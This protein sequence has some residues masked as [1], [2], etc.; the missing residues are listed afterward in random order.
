MP[1]QSAKNEKKKTDTGLT[2]KSKESLEGEKRLREI[3]QEINQR[4]SEL[5]EERSQRQCYPLLMFTTKIGDRLVEDVFDDLRKEYSNCD[6]Q[7][8]IL[9]FSSGG[10]IDAAYN[11]ALLLRKFATKDLV[12]IIPRWAKSAAT[13]LACSGNRILMSPIAEL[14]PLDPQITEV[15]PLQRRM[16]Q[17]SPLHIEATLSLIREEFD[18][19]HEKLAKGLLER[20]QFPLTLGSFKKS[21]DIAKEYLEML[22][23]TRMLS[24]NNKQDNAKRMAEKLTQGYPDHSYCIDANEA[25]AIGLIVDDLEG[26]LLDIC[27]D[28]HKLGREKDNIKK[29][30]K[31]QQME[32]LLKELPP[33]LRDML[34]DFLK[35]SPAAKP[36]LP[37]EESSL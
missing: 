22:L 13:L 15:N 3:D 19:G 2:P 4:L 16:E 20:L 11:L 25:R 31:R 29:T 12:F 14:G 37:P 6:G 28:I 1:K 26:R 10:D 8:D 32:E 33:E 7:L 30:Q 36:A 35:P 24:G 9:L 17:F 34:P 18:R 23:S 21:L 5:R 27:W